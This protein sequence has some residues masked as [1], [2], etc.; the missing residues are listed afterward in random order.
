MDNLLLTDDGNR[1]LLK[2]YKEYKQRR[3]QKRRERDARYFGDDVAVQQMLFPEY[4]AEQ[5]CDICWFLHQKGLLH[6][7]P[8]DDKANDIEFTDD[9]IAYMETRMSRKIEKGIDILSKLKP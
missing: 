1:V 9:G 2:L 7:L 5:I 3:K 4:S 8:G 6:V